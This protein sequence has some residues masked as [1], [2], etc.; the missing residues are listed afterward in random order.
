M[1]VLEQ[2]TQTFLTSNASLDCLPWTWP[3]KQQLVRLT[4]VIP[5]AVIQLGNKTPIL[6]NYEIYVIH[7][8]PGMIAG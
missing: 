8:I 4:L 5:L 1:I 6:G 3:R 2:P 7:G